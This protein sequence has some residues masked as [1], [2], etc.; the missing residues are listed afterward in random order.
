[1]IV[2]EA[3]RQAAPQILLEGPT[4]RDWFNE[5]YKIKKRNLQNST[6][7]LSVTNATQVISEGKLNVF[8]QVACVFFN[9]ED[10]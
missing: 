1:M 9:I 6:D 5:Q 8:I 3:R 10:V 2:T 7:K 4:V